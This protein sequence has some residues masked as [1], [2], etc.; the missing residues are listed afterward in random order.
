M[1]MDSTLGVIF[2]IGKKQNNSEILDIYVPITVNKE[3][4]EF[5]TKRY[6]A[7]CNWDIFRCRA[8]E[9]D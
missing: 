5:N 9:T 4:A 2:F 3:R 8:K 1:R 6:I 7:V